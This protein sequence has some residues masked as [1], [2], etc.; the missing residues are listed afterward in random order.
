[1]LSSILFLRYRQGTFCECFIFFGSDRIAADVKNYY[2]F[3][4]YFLGEDCLGF[5]AY[6]EIYTNRVIVSASICLYFVLNRK[7]SIC[8]KFKV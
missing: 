8:L 1:V 7:V 6:L 5:I 3:H 4:H 2:H